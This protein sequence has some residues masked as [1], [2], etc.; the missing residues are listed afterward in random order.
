M[1]IFTISKIMAIFYIEKKKESCS[2][3]DNFMTYSKLVNV[4]TL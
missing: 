2:L 3:F 1:L 4:G